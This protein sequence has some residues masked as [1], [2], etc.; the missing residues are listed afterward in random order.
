MAFHEELV[1]E[2]VCFPIIFHTDIVVPSNISGGAHW[3]RSLEI[4]CTLSGNGF[5]LIDG[6]K[7]LMSAGDVIVVPSGSIHVTGTEEGACRYYCLIIDLDFLTNSGVWREYDRLP[8]CVHDEQSADLLEK[9]DREMISRPCFYKE[10][11]KALVLQFVIGLRR[12]HPV[13]SRAQSAGGEVGRM[14]TVRK[15]IAAIDREFERS[16][17]LDYLCQVAG[18]SKYYFCRAFKHA[19]GQTVTQYV[20]W[21]R[22]DQA[23]RLLASGECNVGEAAERCGFHNLSYFTKIYRR[24]YGHAPSQEKQ[25]TKAKGSPSE[26]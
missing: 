18:M 2:D 21:V 25:R 20:N 22:C 6:E 12:R 19:T 5:V 10:Q 23:R 9:I 1:H 26:S 24:Q 16:I 7:V 17:T 8:L 14:D 15:A 4:L 13:E 3:H 11:V